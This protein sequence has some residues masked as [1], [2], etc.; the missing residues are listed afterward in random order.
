[1]LLTIG[2][3]VEEDD[4]FVGSIATLTFQHKAAI[5]PA[6]DPDFNEPTHW[7]YANGVKIGQARKDRNAKHGCHLSVKLDDPSFKRPFSCKLLNEGHGH[8]RLVWNR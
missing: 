8:H 3:F 1:M 2:I 5:V 6:A 7:V 4:N